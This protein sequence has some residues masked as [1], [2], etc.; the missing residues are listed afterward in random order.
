MPFLAVLALLTMSPDDIMARTI[1]A[2]RTDTAAWHA[3]I[4]LLKHRTIEKDS[5]PKTTWDFLVYGANGRTTEQLKRRDGVPTPDEP[6][7]PVGV[8]ILRIITERAACYTFAFAKVRTGAHNGRPVYI[9]TF[10][11]RTSSCSFNGDEERIAMLTAGTVWVDRERFCIW[12]LEGELSKPIT[13]RI[14]FTVGSISSCSIE[15]EQIAIGELVIPS[16]LTTVVEYGSI[17]KKKTVERRTVTYDMP[18]LKD[19]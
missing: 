8:D 1:A 7:Q 18:A 2:T 15:F 4:T 10:T 12:K 13:K 9:L 14:I 19:P 3:R 11:P 5:E 16:R 6:A 17:L